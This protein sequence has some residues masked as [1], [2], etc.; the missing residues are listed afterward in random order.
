M[1]ASYNP[2]VPPGADPQ[3]IFNVLPP[4]SGRAYEILL[5]IMCLCLGAL[6][7]ELLNHLRFDLRLMRK[8]GWTDPAKLISRLAYFVCRYLSITILILIICFIT[9]ESDNCT[10]LPMTFNIMGMFLLDAVLL[11]F[12]QRTMALYNWSHSVTIPLS[13]FYCIVVVSSVVCTPFYGVGFRIPH[14]G[15]CGYDTRSY[16]TRTIV[17]NVIFRALAISLDTVLLLLT[18]HRLLDGGLKAVWHKKPQQLFSSLHDS[19][20]SGFLIRQGLHF[21]VLQLGTDIFFITTYFSFTENAYKDLGTAFAFSIPPIV[22]AAAFREMGKKASMVTAKKAK[23]VNEIINS[24]DTP[25]GGISVRLGTVGARISAVEPSARVPTVLAEP[26]S[27]TG[28][29][30]FVLQARSNPSFSGSPSPGKI[31]SSRVSWTAGRKSINRFRPDAI[32]AE[33]S[34]VLITVGAVSRIDDADQEWEAGSPRYSSDNNDPDAIEIRRQWPNLAAQDAAGSE[35]VAQSYDGDDVKE[36]DLELGDSGLES[37]HI[38]NLPSFQTVAGN[39]DL[40]HLYG[41]SIGSSSTS[42]QPS[43]PDSPY[44]PALLSPSAFSRRLPPSTSNAPS[45]RAS[46][47]VV[48]EE[49]IGRASDTQ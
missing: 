49:E 1:S 34:G 24:A 27:P 16:L 44:A 47:R 29:N 45:S 41:S 10:A 32:A 25:S 21:F 6:I 9:L 31:S 30:A 3:I 13:V 48:E 33:D 17:A 5:I 20:L 23:K 8:S 11:V 26:G 42:W 15:F 38:P 2:N 4:S 22:A 18:L 46:F 36:K 12:V 14:T 35:A 40:T 19:S 7:M 28:V 37:L 39:P 43:S